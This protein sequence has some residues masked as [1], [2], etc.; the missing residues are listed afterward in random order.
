[1]RVVEIGLDQTRRTDRMDIPIA[2]MRFHQIAR[3]EPRGGVA[4]DEHALERPGRRDVAGRLETLQ[5]IQ[6]LFDQANEKPLADMLPIMQR[7][8][9]HFAREAGTPVL[10]S[11]E[12]KDV[13]L[14]AGLR[15]LDE[16]RE[17]RVAIQ[18][19]LICLWL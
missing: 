9:E 17:R 5:T 11:G 15:E 19:Q 2:R 7:F 4:R 18:R 1:M 13:R 16:H 8:V 6:V 14:R 10:G 12:R 3:A